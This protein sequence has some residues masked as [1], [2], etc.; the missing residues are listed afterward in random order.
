MTTQIE[1]NLQGRHPFDDLGFR[2]LCCL[3]ASFDVQ[4]HF[5]NTKL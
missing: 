3:G 5:H 2:L 4:G 1:A